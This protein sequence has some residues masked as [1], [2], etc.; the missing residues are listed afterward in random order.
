GFD[1]GMFF[2]GIGKREAWGDGHLAIAGYHVKDGAMPQAI[3]GNYWRPDRTDAFYPRAWSLGLTAGSAPEG[4]IMRPQ[5]R[6][7][8]DMS[9]FRV[10]NISLGYALPENL[11]RNAKLS[12]ARIYIS[13]ENLITFD[14][15]RGLPIDP[16]AI[17]GVSSLTSG[18]YNYS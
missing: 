12:R 10:K 3:A 1:L 2:Q 16:E 7:L 11:I 17:N 9:Y 5:T 4:W 6:Y 15:L 13:L 8:L 14:N 18:N